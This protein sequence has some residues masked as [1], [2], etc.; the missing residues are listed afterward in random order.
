MFEC[1]DLVAADW[2][3]ESLLDAQKGVWHHN[4]AQRKALQ[5]AL[6]L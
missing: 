1:V 3:R 6:I 2:N 4:S 5:Q